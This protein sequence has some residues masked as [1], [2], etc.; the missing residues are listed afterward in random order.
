MCYLGFLFEFESM[1]IVK[2]LDNNGLPETDYNLGDKMPLSLQ[3]KARRRLEKKIHHLLP[4]G[5]LGLSPN[6]R[7]GKAEL[8]VN[9]SSAEASVE[10]WMTRIEASMSKEVFSF[11]LAAT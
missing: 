9:S 1:G 5:T 6:F 8:V 10:F 7:V 2:R 4:Q 3:N 11:W